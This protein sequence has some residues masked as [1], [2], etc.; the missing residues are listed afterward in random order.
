MFNKKTLLCIDLLTAIGSVP[1]GAVV[2]SLALAKRLT[3]SV[4]HVESILRLLREADLVTS[5]RGPGGGYYISRHP[6]L[7]NVWEVISA[8][9][10]NEIE[11]SPSAG[12]N[13]DISSLEDAL[14]RE[15][16]RFLSSK[17]I[18]EFIN[19]DSTWHDHAATVRRNFGLGPKPISLM[20]VAPNS[21]FQLSSFLQN[22]LA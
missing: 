21:V 14:A 13:I 8:I 6:D 15:V 1:R 16:Q 17:T 18:G 11:Q 20:P 12:A 9:E 4:S 22:V 7:I 5:I 10:C 3:I 19:T 2:T